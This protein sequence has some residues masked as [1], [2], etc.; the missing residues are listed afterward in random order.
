MMK[1]VFV[2]KRASCITSNMHAG[3]RYY[4]YG[5]QFFG[6]KFTPRFSTTPVTRPS[7]ISPM[8]G[9]VTG[10]PLY[11]IINTNTLRFYKSFQ[12]SLC[13][14]LSDPDEEFDIDEENEKYIEEC[15]V[16]SFSCPP[17]T[18]VE[19]ALYQQIPAILTHKTSRYCHYRCYTKTCDHTATL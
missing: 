2:M 12:F 10:V 19:H 9:H 5:T 14:F 3:K 17:T 1:T 13:K 7:D 4:V 16:R 15:E 8:V 18:I 6:G 11:I